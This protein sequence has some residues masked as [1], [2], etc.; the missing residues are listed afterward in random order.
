[1]LRLGCLPP[2]SKFLATRL[3]TDEQDDTY[4]DLPYL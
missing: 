4:D 3:D 2:P 1:M